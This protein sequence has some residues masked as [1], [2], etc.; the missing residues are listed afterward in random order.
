MTLVSAASTPSAKLQLE[1]P[2]IG[3]ALVALTPSIVEVAAAQTVTIDV[4]KSSPYLDEQAKSAALARAK[5]VAASQP[6]IVTLADPG[7]GAKAVLVQK[8]AASVG[9]DWKVLAAVWQIESGRQWNTAERNPTGAQGPCQFLPST[10]RHWASDGNGDGTANINQAED[11]LFGAAKLLAS[12]GAASG[13][14]TKALLSYNHSLAYVAKVLRIA[15][16]MA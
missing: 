9:M 3:P 7:D 5:A 6:L 16:S 4:T 13:N 14:V 15:E 12:N 10:W 8:A 11:C 1:Q 2:T